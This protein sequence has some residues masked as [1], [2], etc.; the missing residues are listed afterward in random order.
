MAEKMELKR[1]PRK[2]QP[3]PEEAAVGTPFSESAP[4]EA[5][6][7]ASAA[8]RPRRRRSPYQIQRNVRFTVENSDLL[9]HMADVTSKTVQEL[10][11]EAIENMVTSKKWSAS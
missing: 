7:P 1:K 8:G 10:I 9:D 5:P 3:A 4:A 6:A 11:H 2:P